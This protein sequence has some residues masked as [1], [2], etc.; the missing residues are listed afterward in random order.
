VDVPDLTDVGVREAPSWPVVAARVADSV[1]RVHGS[2]VVAMHSNA[3]IYASHIVAARARAIEALIFADASV[4]PDRGAAEVA[5]PEFVAELRAKAT[6]GVLPRWTE[7]WPEEDVAALFPDEATMRRVVE[8]QP[9]VPLRYY[10]RMIPIEPGWSEVPC[11]YLLFSEGYGDAA[12]EARARGWPVVQ[13][14]GEHLHMVV[15]PAAVGEALE[16]LA[17]TLGG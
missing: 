16:R 7:W 17:E 11:G 15:D 4:P 12:A 13:V 9:R 8:E 1:D 5:P 2:A 10:E 14:P 3:G 6:D